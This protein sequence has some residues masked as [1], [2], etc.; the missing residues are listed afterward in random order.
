MT[1][2]AMYQPDVLVDDLNYMTAFVARLT[3]KPR[4]AVVRKGVIPME[5]YT[6]G[7]NHSSE[8]VGYFEQVK[9]M[10]LSRQG[11][12]EPS[13]VSD[14]FVGDR[15]IIPSVPSIEKLPPALENKHTYRYSGALVLRDDE[16]S[17]ALTYSAE[18]HT[19]MV[20]FLEKNAGKKVVYFT[21]GLASPPEIL[22]RAEGCIR[23]L[24][25]NPDVALITNIP[26]SGRTLEDPGR[27]FRNSYFP[28]NF[29]CP[30]A[31][32]MIHQCGSGTY[33][34]QIMNELPGIA[35]GSRC[36]DRDDVA[37]EL[38]KSGAIRFISADLDD[39][40]YMKSFND[41]VYQLL[42]DSGAAH[43]DQKSALERLK[44]E[45]IDAQSRFDFGALVREVLQ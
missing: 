2:V 21:V 11:F 27:V 16:M 38:E 8:I 39:E 26:A 37:K 34:Y 30:N 29:V 25:N 42:D 14:L 41:A 32:L 22:K 1:T 45:M 19:S 24:L 9:S 7:Y 44:R 5:T 31:D 23:A 15:H 35:L 28:M 20:A 40:A 6:P 10:N 33:N 3:K 43:R 17:G 12:W 18:M 36:Y 4:I 13:S